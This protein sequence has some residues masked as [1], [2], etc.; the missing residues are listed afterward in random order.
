[1]AYRYLLVSVKPKASV[2]TKQEIKEALWPFEIPGDR[3]SL[4]NEQAKEK[5]HGRYET[6]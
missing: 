4:A 5:I 3:E 2:I 6:R 1:M